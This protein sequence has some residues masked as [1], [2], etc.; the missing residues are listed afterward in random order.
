MPT[1]V[2]TTSS[3]RL[4][5]EQ[6]NKIAEDITEVHCD[7]TG[8]PKYFVQIIFNEVSKE[9]YFLGGKQLSEDNIYIH[10]HIRNGRTLSSKQSIINDI[11]TRVASASDADISS[12]QTYITDIPASQVAEFGTI[13][14]EPG[15]EDEWEKQQSEVA[16]ARMRRLS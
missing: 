6:K 10:A 15:E 7:R 3:K 14:P 11:V 16:R 2:V 13:L 5:Q 9:N 12:I 1:Y 4:A 8:A